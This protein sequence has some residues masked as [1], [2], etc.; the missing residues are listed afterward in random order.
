MKAE[1]PDLQAVMNRIQKLLRLS[2]SSNPHEASLAAEKAQELMFAYGLSMAQVEA[3]HEDGRR[4]TAEEIRLGSMGSI[5][6]KRSLFAHV[7]AACWCK[8]LWRPAT[9]IGIAVGRRHN[10]MLVEH[11]YGYLHREIERMAEATGSGSGTHN[12]TVPPS[13]SISATAP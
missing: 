7:A 8:A 12:S 4:F 1:S 5:S 3:A 9:A 11:L 6:W 2:K 13:S 10:V